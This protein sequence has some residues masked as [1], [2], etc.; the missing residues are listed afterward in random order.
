MV[1]PEL[2]AP[3]FPSAVEPGA[4]AAALAPRWK[5]QCR[6]ECWEGLQSKREGEGKLEAFQ[7]GPPL[8]S[9]RVCCQCTVAP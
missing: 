2:G 8:S 6:L 4:W 7:C 1:L 3:P 9:D 5:A